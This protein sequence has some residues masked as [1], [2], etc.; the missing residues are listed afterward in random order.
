MS[1]EQA[2]IDPT[3][4]KKKNRLFRWLL[5]FAVIAVL[6]TVSIPPL[7]DRHWQIDLIEKIERAGGEVVT[8][9][10]GP[11]WLR[12]ILGEDRLSGFENV[13]TVALYSPEV[14]DIWLE[15]LVKL[16]E[17]KHLVLE[18]TGVT[19]AGLAQVSGLNHLQSL[20]LTNCRITD[21]GLE[22]LKGLAGLEYLNLENTHVTDVGVMHLSSMRNMDYLNLKGTKITD[23]SLVHLKGFTRMRVLNLDETEVTDA[24]VKRL[25][26]ALPNCAI[27]WAGSD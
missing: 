16:R 21:T 9:P 5:F 10:V 24:G 25:Q 8:D 13:V 15:E 11:E 27:V 20:W 6:I 19:D 26:V 14:T 1:D 18:N 23:A 12:E 7:L 17:L 4:G 22:H 3:P 2:S